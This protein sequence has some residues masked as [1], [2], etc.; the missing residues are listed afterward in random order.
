MLSLNFQDFNQV[1]DAIDRM[2]TYDNIKHEI[3]TMKGEDNN[4][5]L[6]RLFERPK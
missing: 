5:H 6:V 1:N 2:Y 4:A 3:V